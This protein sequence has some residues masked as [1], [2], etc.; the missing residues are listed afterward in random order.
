MEFSDLIIQILNTI[1]SIFFT[2]N[3]IVLMHKLYNL[4]KIEAVYRDDT[5]AH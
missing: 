4:L 2:L 3:G 5:A 1:S